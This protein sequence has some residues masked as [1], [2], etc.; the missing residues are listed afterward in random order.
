MKHQ[1]LKHLLAT[2]FLCLAPLAQAE[3]LIDV[4]EIAAQNDPQIRAAEAAYQAAREATP[5]ARASLLPQINASY[6]LSEQDQTISDADNPALNGDNDSSSDGWT[7]RLDQSIY[8]HQYWVAL[9][10][11]SDTVAQAEAELAAARQALFTRV[12]EAYFAVLA[13]EDTLRFAQAEKEAI[14]RQLEQ[15]ER[16]FE[17]GLIAITDVKESQAQ[18]DLAVAA[19]IDAIN[20]LDNARE[21]LQVLTGRYL[22]NLTPLGENLP[23]ASPD[24]M[25]LQAWE[26]RA[27]EQN[28]SLRAARFATERTR[29]EIQRQRA[30]HYPTFDLVASYSEFDNSSARLGGVTSDFTSEDASIGVQANLPIFSGGRTSSLTSQARSLFQQAQEELELT[31]RETSRLTRASYLNVMSDISRVRALEQ[32]LISTRT[33]AEATQAGFEVGT[34]TSV[35]VLLA[36]RETYR[37]ERDYASARYT[38]I[39]NTLRLK[40]AAGM[41]ARDDLEAVNNWLR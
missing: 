39:L 9:S 17:V 26:E 6:Q 7:L 1:T 5:Q 15:T 32:A 21:S 10:Q 14:A 11:A 36:L 22:D 31:R 29:R 23:L 30:G 25:D 35:D 41:L 27:M 3:D 24:P 34:R 4:Y 37:A 12:A 2:L 38:Y 33:A 19:E 16:R 20:V 13:A 8:N 28:L 40:Q 18:Y